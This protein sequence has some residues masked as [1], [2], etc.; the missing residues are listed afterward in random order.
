M[1]KTKYFFYQVDS[2]EMTRS[3][4]PE[5]FGSTIN[6]PKKLGLIQK[7]PKYKTKVKNIY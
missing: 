6:R 2:T 3:G 4:W 5:I 7:Q 1:K